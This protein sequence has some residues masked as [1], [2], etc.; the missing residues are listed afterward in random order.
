[1]ECATTVHRETVDSGSTHSA[2]EHASVD[3]RGL[4]WKAGKP[5]IHGHHGV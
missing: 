4:Y 5:S 1:M 3:R 2:A